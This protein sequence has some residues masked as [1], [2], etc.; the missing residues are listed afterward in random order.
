[1][2]P[3]ECLLDRIDQ[4]R[5]QA[6]ADRPDGDIVNKL[7]SD[8]RVYFAGVGATH[9]PPARQEGVSAGTLEQA[10]SLYR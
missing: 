8:I 6:A 9:C 7:I 10:R 3:R 1:M 4:L 2:S 5:A